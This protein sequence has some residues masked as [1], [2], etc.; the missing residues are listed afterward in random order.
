MDYRQVVYNA[1]QH[2]VE[3]LDPDS[4]DVKVKFNIKDSPLLSF[5]YSTNV[6]DTKGK[7]SITLYPD[8]LK[9]KE[10]LLKKINTLDIVNIY[11]NITGKEQVTKPSFTGIVKT[12]KYVS[13]CSDSVTRRLVVSGYSVAGLIDQFF[14]NLDVNATSITAQAAGDEELRFTVNNLTDPSSLPT[15]D[16]VVDNMWKSFCS[17]AKMY[18]K[19]SSI[20][21]LDYIEKYVGSNPFD[22]ESP[23]K[24]HYPLGSVFAGQ[25]TQNFYSILN[26]LCTQPVYESFVFRD[27]EGKMRVKVREVP[28]DVGD[29]WDK[30][31][32]QEIKP[33]DVKGFDFSLSDEEV[34]TIFFSYLDG[35]AIQED[36]ALKT[37][38]VETRQDSSLILYDEKYQ[39]YGYRP[40]FA[41]FKGYSIQT[42]KKDTSTQDNI[43][44]LNS[45]L[46][47]WYG[48][49]ENMLNGTINISCKTM[50]EMPVTGGK[51]KFLGGE[52][53]VEGVEVK[54]NYGGNTEA[55]LIVSRG[56]KYD[57]GEFE[58][59]EDIAD[60]F[61]MIE[62]AKAVQQ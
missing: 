26:V 57:S 43:T 53:Y 11:Q 58:P 19:L 9:T 22:F 17:L 54:W 62:A 13:Q 52:F 46:R 3:F 8:D 14:I 27:D 23:P 29:T 5:S 6:R 33:L 50:D 34:Y 40:L 59:F 31:P 16:V 44:K 45:R 32:T 35:Y 4:G 12:R 49:L 56:G 15:L 47:D 25:T 51:I 1:P 37:Q 38:A 30:L 2:I 36:I 48:N 10:H 60:K 39:K 28:F 41:N 20:K 18:K 61:A 7:F 21:M 55:T 42:G 24:L